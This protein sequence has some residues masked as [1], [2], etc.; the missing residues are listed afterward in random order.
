MI[1]FS[2]DLE[3][4]VDGINPTEEIIQVGYTAFNSITGE[5]LETSGDY[6]TI[7][8]PLYPFII[9]LTGITQ[10]EIDTRGVSISQSYKN[11]L[12]FCEKHEIKFGQ[13]VTWGSGDLD[14]YK[15]SVLES[16][17]EWVFGRTEFNLKAFYQAYRSINGLGH[18]GGLKKSMK[19][20]NVEWQVYMDQLPSGN[21]KQRTAHDARCDALNTAVFY[22]HLVSKLRGV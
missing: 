22:N 7:S 11:L 6:I 4:N 18:S 13:M 5:I 10:N 9:K 15:K 8:K 3:L 21:K 1:R 2:L 20:C 17:E 14:E 19:N 16:G 12:N